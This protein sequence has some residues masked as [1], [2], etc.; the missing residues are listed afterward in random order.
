MM[1]CSAGAVLGLLAA[2]GCAGQA[3][4]ETVRLDANGASVT[5]PAGWEARAGEAGAVILGPP[6]MTLRHRLDLT[7]YPAREG[8]E[9]PLL[10]ERTVEDAG[11]SFVVIEGVA[12]SWPVEAWVAYDRDLA[13]MRQAI[14][15]IQPLP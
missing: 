5:V 13:A 8:A 14:E 2:L 4:E 6:P 12:G 3:P 7:I 10:R 1:K 15:S 11:E 9:P